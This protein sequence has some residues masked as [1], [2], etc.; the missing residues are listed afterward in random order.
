MIRWLR[1]FFQL[2][3][4]KADPQDAPPSRVVFGLA[5]LA[6]FVFTV[7]ALAMITHSWGR[8]LFL[9]TLQTAIY[10]FAAHLILW[11]SRRQERMVQ[12]LT[13]LC[14]A[15]AMVTVLTMPVFAWA[16]PFAGESMA[17]PVLTILAVL[18]QAVVIAHIFRHAL[19]IPFIAG[20]GI[21]LIFIW[22]AFA[23]TL[24]FMRILVFTVG[25]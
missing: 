10:L 15:N 3:F 6:Y 23:V 2:S 4:L 25:G 20:L 5:V 12:T 22:V 1:Y 7:S 19:E 17:L 8:T 9:A 24:R 11:I 16:I 14:G 13:A 21:A 18:W